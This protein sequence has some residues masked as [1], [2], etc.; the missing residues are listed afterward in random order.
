MS[1]LEEQLKQQ[2]FLNDS[3]RWSRTSNLLINEKSDTAFYVRLLQRQTTHSKKG[4]RV[5]SAKFD[6]R[7]AAE[8]HAY[9]FR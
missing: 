9:P 7:L 3:N 2:A 5:S 6:T 4:K 1:P 8:N